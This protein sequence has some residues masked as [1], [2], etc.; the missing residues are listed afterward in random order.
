LAEGGVLRFATPTH[1][2]VLDGAASLDRRTAADAAPFGEDVTTNSSSVT[3]L[4]GPRWYRATSSHLARFLGLGVAG[5]YGHSASPTN[6]YRED[7][8]SAGAYGEI[9]VQYMFTPHLGFGWRATLTG[10][11][12]QDRVTQTVGTP[13]IQ[14]VTYYHLAVEPVQVSGTVYF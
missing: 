12:T 11:R 10:S 7:I 5:S 2:W 6:S 4:F 14:R 13:L 1:A 3:V 8:W 9:G